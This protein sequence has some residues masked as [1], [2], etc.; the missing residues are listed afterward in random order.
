[1]EVTNFVRIL[2]IQP[3]TSPKRV[4]TKD[5]QWND[6][7]LAIA[8]LD[9]GN[10]QFVELLESSDEASVMTVYG[11]AGAYHIG[12]IND[13]TEES[14]LMLEPETEERVEISGNLFPK[15]QVCYDRQ[16]VQ[17]VIRRFFESG[18]RSTEANWF[19]IEMDD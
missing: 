9:R 14:W 3:K 7:E 1:M 5:P 8:D 11:E 4:V 18:V 6:I 16:L 19:T 17:A 2:S 12:I 10:S 15:N 13:E